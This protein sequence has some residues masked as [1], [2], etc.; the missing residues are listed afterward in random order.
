[1]YH[2]NNQRYDFYKLLKTI[3]ISKT[4]PKNF[5]NEGEKS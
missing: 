2:N 5:Q 4:I 3:P 1:M